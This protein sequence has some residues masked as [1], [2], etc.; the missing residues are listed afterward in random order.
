MIRLNRF[1][2]LLVIGM[3]AVPM[4]M[5]SVIHYRALEQF[6]TRTMLEQLE[7]EAFVVKEGLDTEL[8][9]LIGGLRLLTGHETIIKGVSSLYY[10][11]QVHDR[12][13]AFVNRY[14]LV[15]SLYLVNQD[16][17]VRENYG[18]NIRH[19]EKNPEIQELLRNLA[20]AYQTG[21][22]G[23]RI[24]VIESADLAVGTDQ[25]V[26][27]FISIVNSVVSRNSDS[28]QG[29][30]VA[31]VPFGN[32]QAMISQS[33]H[34]PQSATYL[35]TSLPPDQDDQISQSQKL[36][37]AE[38]DYSPGQTLYIKVSRSSENMGSAVA[39]AIR[40]FV[41]FELVVMTLMVFL[42]IP[43][44]RPLWRSFNGLYDIIKQMDEGMLVQ[45]KPSR[46]WEFA[47]TERILMEMQTKIRQQVASLED[48][49][50]SL[51]HLSAEKDR[52]LKELSKL[53]H[54]LEEKV[55]ERTN[56][57]AQILQRIEISNCIYNQVINLRQE[58][59]A[60][61]SEQSVMQVVVKCLKAC[62]LSVPF[63]VVL[64]N[65]N[66]PTLTHQQPDFTGHLMMP[67]P[68]PA[69]DYLFDNGVYC[70]PLPAPF[71]GGW[72]YVQTIHLRE[73]ELKGMLLFAR[74]L[75][76]FLEN[77]ALTSRLA[78]WAR[79]DGLT[80][81]GNRIAFDQAMAD[82]EVKLDGAMVLLLIDVNGLKELNDSRGHEAGDALLRT[83]ASRL[84]NC[85]KGMSGSLY[86]IGGG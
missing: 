26:L 1:F 64:A 28:L 83:V 58:L 34:S 12:F 65:G 47:H 44:S 66:E 36:V 9:S 80:G 50:Q 14:K 72:L 22:A 63:A 41:S 48:N 31:I 35:G 45:R 71:G 62:E 56:K 86:R 13:D 17:R 81:L 23:G 76:N 30:L 38:K 61:S 32:M 67:M 70:I 79:T 78:F 85:L 77:R 7:S 84:K 49:N 10:A 15:S 43:L 74:E 69:I 21:M 75:G 46:I 40:P 57:L 20:Q 11:T 4:L 18:G 39:Q 24:A 51:A 3:L 82:A 5:L 59:N 53:N 33:P 37:I 19:I 16:G 60:E 6:A 54:N 2:L 25:R 27:A 68:N 42:C 29:F 8:R 73:E 55:Q 52:Y